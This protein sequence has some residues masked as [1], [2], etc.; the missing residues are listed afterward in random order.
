MDKIKIDSR[1]DICTL[2]CKNFKNR[3]TLWGPYYEDGIKFCEV[4]VKTMCI[5]CRNLLNR[6]EKLESELLDI[7]FEIF[8]LSNPIVDSRN[9]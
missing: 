4:E 2:C 7:D 5:K 8:C 3:K 9:F 1:S 6:K